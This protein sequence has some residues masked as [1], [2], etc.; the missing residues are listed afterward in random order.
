MEEI[1][2]FVREHG[3]WKTCY[4]SGP[5]TGLPNHNYEAFNA[6]AAELR[7]IGK[8]VFNPAE[9]FGGDQTRSRA[10]Y[11]RVD[12]NMILDSDVIVVLPGWRNSQG[13]TVE[14][15]IGRE[16]G[17]PILDYP[18]LTPVKD[19]TVCEEAERIVG[20]DRSPQ[21]GHPTKNFEQTADLWMD[22][23]GERD[24]AQDPI[25]PKDVAM[26]MILLKIA[27]E[28]NRSKRDNVVD[29]IGYAK[30]LAMVHNWE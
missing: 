13:A 22:Y 30:T 2:T 26:M 6:V 17:L 20:G 29:I 9:N 14:V 16:L 8:E 3:L 19:E 10:E 18:S 23:L 24:L 21:Y 4:I 11:M 12:I 15:P 28:S 1:G 27:R 5:M 25:E 7:R